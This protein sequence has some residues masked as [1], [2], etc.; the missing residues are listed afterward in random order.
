VAEGETTHIEARAGSSRA[1]DEP[2]SF[3]RQR[4]RRCIDELC[5]YIFRLL[6]Y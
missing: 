4:K 6:E 3:N 1:T 2:E 5:L